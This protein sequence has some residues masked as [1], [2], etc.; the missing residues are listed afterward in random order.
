MSRSCPKAVTAIQRSSTHLAYESLSDPVKA[1][2]DGL[3]A[4]GVFVAY[5]QPERPGKLDGHA[6]WL[7]ERLPWHR[8]N[9]DV[10]VDLRAVERAIAPFR[11]EI[12][13]EARAR[14]GSN[15]EVI[16]R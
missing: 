4:A 10:T 3:T 15:C 6:G 14:R 8:G 5:K 13:A 9:A 12:D 16:A 1:L 7:R 11:Q 2:L